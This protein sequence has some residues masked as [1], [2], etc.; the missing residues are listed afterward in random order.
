MKAI[1]VKA[2]RM[3]SLVAVFDLHTQYF[4]NVI[5]GISDTDALQRLNTKANHIAWLAGSLVHQ[6][7]IMT[8]DLA[9][10]ETHAGYE[11]FK[12]FKGIQD[13]AKYPTLAEYL[14]DWERLT[15]IAREALLKIDDAKLEEP[16]DMGG[17]QMT[18]FD[19]QAFI[20]HREAYFIGQI[21][22]WRRLLG[23]EAMKYM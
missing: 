3:Y 17:Q 6:R 5:E 9:P 22:L 18:F 13:D 2:D 19:L 10:N 12:D 4:K 15:P 14:A 11:L 1:P 8:R 20:P 16:F 7:F 21:G 23:Y